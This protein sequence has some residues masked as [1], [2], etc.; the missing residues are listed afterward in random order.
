MKTLRTICKDCRC[1]EKS[2]QAMS[3][4]EKAKEAKTAGQLH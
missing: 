4:M 3:E 1:D 2:I